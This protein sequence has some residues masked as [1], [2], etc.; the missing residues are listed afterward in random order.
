MD[1]RAVRRLLPVIGL[2]FSLPALC[3]AEDIYVAEN[4]AGADTGADCAN[5]HSAT[6]FNTA[7]NWGGAVGLISAG[8]TVHLC[9]TYTGSPGQTG[10]T[11]QASG[12]AGNPI[13][14]L[15]KPNAVMRAPY[16]ASGI[17]LKGQD[18]LIIDGGTN[19][20]IE[21]TD[22]GTNL[23]FQAASTGV[24][25]VGC[26][27]I[28]VR[29]LTIRNLYIRQQD[30]TDYSNGAS[31]TAN[32]W[33]TGSG[34]NM[35]VHNNTLSYSHATIILHPNSVS[36]VSHTGYEVYSNTMSQTHWGLFVELFYG[37]TDSAPSL[38]GLLVHDNSFT[39]SRPWFDP[40][41]VYHHD[42][43]IISADAGSGVQPSIN[44]CQVYN[45]Y[46]FGPW[47]Q[48]TGGIYISSNTHNCKIYNN[49]ITVEVGTGNP[50]GGWG[51]ALGAIA[52][53][54]GPPGVSNA[55]YN[56]TIINGGICLF[57]SGTDTIFKNNICVSTP[58]GI[59]VHPGVGGDPTPTLQA[60]DN[61]L[62]FDVT[63]QGT[64]GA[65]CLRGTCTNTLTGWQALSGMDLNSTSTDP[66]LDA[67]YHLQAASAAIG[68]GANLTD[69]NITGLN[70]DKAGDARPSSGPWDA[71]VYVFAPSNGPNPLTN[72]TAIVR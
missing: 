21:N 14:L 30:T 44:N 31:G 41:G 3:F 53:G 66:K 38:D 43:F 15:F 50:A 19:G 46:V 8:D 12:T 56:N 68:L 37:G 59:F 42:P 51:A 65:Y 39:D 58:N 5:A 63:G 70:S 4:A 16:W 69:L 23:T 33:L 49:L 55:A 27:D 67:T 2:V 60:S 36:G 22:N 1:H 18:F 47:G 57:T 24:R 34:N 11:F 32:I 7:A 6:W 64:A 9:G 28:E 72:L 61:N 26:S 48:A 54:S 62:F 10:L 45:N 13:T 17:E 35:S 29:N 20:V 40:Q 52:F 25:C 71:G